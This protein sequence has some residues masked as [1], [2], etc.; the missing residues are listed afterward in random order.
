MILILKPVF[1]CN[2]WREIFEITVSRKKMVTPLA[3]K[4]AITVIG[5]KQSKRYKTLII[6]NTTG[7]NLNW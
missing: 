4:N 2:L 5:L 7:E 1:K 3:E 6:Y